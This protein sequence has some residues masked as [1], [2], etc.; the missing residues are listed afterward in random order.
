M[1]DDRRYTMRLHST[2]G[3]ADNDQVDLNG[4]L[5]GEDLGVWDTLGKCF[6]KRN[7]KGE[8][9]PDDHPSRK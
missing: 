4:I 1:T 7:A 6:V 3:L 2:A 8:W 5:Y 9:I